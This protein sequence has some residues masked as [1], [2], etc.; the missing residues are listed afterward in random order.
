MST[1]STTADTLKTPANGGVRD[2]RATQN[3]G[4][5]VGAAAGAEQGGAGSA[6]V[7]GAPALDPL[8]SS[9]KL[10]EVGDR[11]L[12]ERGECCGQACTICGPKPALRR[13][14]PAVP[15]EARDAFL[16]ALAAGW[17]VKHAADR[18]G[19]NKRRFYEV[20]DADESFA[21]AWT[22]ALEQG[23]EVL[24]DELRRR[25]VE[26]FDEDTFDGEGKLIRRV[27]RYSPALLIFSLKARR[28]EQYRDNAVVQVTGPGG[29]PVQL[30]AGAQPATLTDMIRLAGELGVLDRLGYSREA[31][32]GEAVEDAPLELEEGQ[33]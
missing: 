2:S 20:R 4:G 11:L 19:I 14:T 18:T 24:E 26:G 28:P 1:V 17:T 31:I 3:P 21:D 32:D 10:A 12:H 25:A 27:R 30:D 29:G 15:A 33:E 6:L 13:R 16:E 7:A 9:P 22:E 23:T 8:G 5:G